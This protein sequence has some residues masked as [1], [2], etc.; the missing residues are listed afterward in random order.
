MALP[1]LELLIPQLKKGAVIITD[2][3]ISAA[4][5]YEAYLAK[6]KGENSGFRTVTLPFKGGLEYTV[7]EG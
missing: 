1:A 5:G 4:K 3:T 2:N 6:I 7:W